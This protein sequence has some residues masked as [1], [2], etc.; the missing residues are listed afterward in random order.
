MIFSDTLHGV[1]V[2]DKELFLIQ[3]DSSKSFNWDGYGLKINVPEG[4]VSSTETCEITVTALI[5]GQ[6]EFPK[7]SE[8][9]SAIYAVSIASEIQQ[10]LT[11]EIQHCV[12]LK[13]SEQSA[14]MRFA[15]ASSKQLPLP[16]QFH[17]LERGVFS[18]DTRYG[19]ISL[20]EFCLV[21][22]LVYP[23]DCIDINFPTSSTTSESDSNEMPSSPI[24]DQ[25]STEVTNIDTETEIE[26]IQPAVLPNQDSSE[27]TSGGWCFCCHLLVVY[28]Y[29][30][31]SLGTAQ[32]YFAQGFY[33]EDEGSNN[34]EMEML[35]V[36]DLD[37]LKQ[38]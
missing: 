17:L 4:T 21:C 38:V 37:F 30:L 18:P 12:S 25:S 7:G 15:K 31:S 34:S 8:L 3:G 14:Y 10:P 24:D 35:V 28:H 2:E 22:V 5:G 13:T 19:A 27:D 36:K 33:K 1:Q 26:C 9:V 6:F 29:I 20:L 16:Y 23:A 11:L 32:T